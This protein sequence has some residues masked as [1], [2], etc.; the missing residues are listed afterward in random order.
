MLQPDHVWDSNLQKFGGML[1]YFVAT[2]NYYLF[3]LFKGYKAL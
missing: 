1:D 2:F 3:C